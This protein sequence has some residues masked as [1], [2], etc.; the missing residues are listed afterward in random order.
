[1]K[2]IIAYIAPEALN[3]VKQALLRAD[4]TKMSVTNALG[5]GAERGYREMYRGAEVEIDLL[6][7]VRLEIAVNDGFVEPTVN[8]ILEH[9]RTDGPDQS[10]DTGDGKIFILQLEDCVRIRTGMRGPHAIG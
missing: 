8:A 5:C 3:P 2:L 10:G 4:V 1:M 9:A 6:K 7:K